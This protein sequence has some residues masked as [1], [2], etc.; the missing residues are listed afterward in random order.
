MGGWVVLVSIWLL[1]HPK[2]QRIMGTDTLI[3]PNMRC[4]LASILRYREDFGWTI[5]LKFCDVLQ[6]HTWGVGPDV[7]CMIKRRIA[8]IFLILVFYCDDDDGQ[9]LSKSFHLITIIP[10]ISSFS[11][12]DIH[13]LNNRLCVSLKENINLL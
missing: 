1:N 9:Y 10:C 3:H 11:I 7:S 13:I 4:T 12:C 5:S 6:H 2:D 8:T